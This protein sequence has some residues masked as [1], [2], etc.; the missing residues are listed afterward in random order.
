MVPKVRY[1]YKTVDEPSNQMDLDMVLNRH[2][3][4]GWE[5]CAID[6]RCLIF[7]RVTELRDDD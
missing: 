2:G 7:K 3:Y 5:L 1:E 6:Y 4:D